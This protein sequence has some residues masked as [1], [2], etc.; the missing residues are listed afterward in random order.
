V[1]A[2]RLSRRAW[3]ATVILVLLTLASLPA[4]PARAQS[5]GDAVVGQAATHYGAPYQWGGAGPNTFDCSGL[6]M[7]VFGHFGVRLPHYTV[8]QYAVSRHVPQNQK[9]P[10]DVI[11]FHDSTGYIYHDGIYGGNNTIIAAT[12]TGD[13]VRRE[14]LWTGAYYVGRYAPI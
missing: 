11:F 5:F 10:G 1:P 7:V 14:T 8:D 2:Y 6:V 4:S 13:V 12:H 9:Q 3:A